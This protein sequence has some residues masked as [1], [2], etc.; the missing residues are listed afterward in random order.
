MKTIP[1][2]IEN[3]NLI[4]LRILTRLYES[5]PTPLDINEENQ[6]IDIIF[7]AVPK[8]ASGEKTWD[9]MAMTD[10]VI[11]WLA[12]EGFLRYE[13]DPNN[14]IG[15]FWKTRLTL[16]GLAILGCVPTSIDKADSKEPLFQK[17]KQAVSSAASTAG[18]ESI[19][20]VVAE[21]FKLALAPGSALANIITT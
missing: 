8:N 11:V 15:Y 9:L 21:I 20:L 5:F 2:N 13:R 10:D 6:S 14:R 12:E 19:K 18:K 3:F 7:D 1:E 4:V 17:A 16:K